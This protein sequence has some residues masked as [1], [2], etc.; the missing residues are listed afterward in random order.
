MN[1]KHAFLAL[2]VTMLWGVNF[3]ALKYGASSLPPFAVT[4]IRFVIVAACLSPWIFKVPKELFWHMLGLSFVMG[5]L[6]FGSLFKGLQGIPSG[7]AC[8][9]VQIEVPF[10]ALLSAWIFREKVKATTWFAIFISIVGVI[11]TVGMPQRLGDLSSIGFLLLAAVFW[12]VNTLQMKKVSSLHP[13]TINGAVCLMAAPQLFL[14]M[15]VT[16]PAAIPLIKIAPV[17][18]WLAISYMAFISTI[19]CYSLWFFLLRKYPVSKVTPF[20]LVSPVTALIAS[21]FLTGEK[22]AVHTLLGTAILLGGLALVVIK[23]DEK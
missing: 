20:Y 19:L 7:E 9:I 1:P 11:V 6:Y 16:E 21:N 10:A 23:R 3:V 5:I 2:L 17:S 14:L 13:F 4:L 18:A 22:L 8:V 15:W 12:A